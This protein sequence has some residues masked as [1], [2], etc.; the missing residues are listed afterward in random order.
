MDSPPVRFSLAF[1]KKV[2]AEFERG[3]LNKDQLQEKYGIR[4]NSTVL[5]WCRKYG[6][7]HY[8]QKGELG[9]PMKDP[10]KQRIKDLEKQLADAKLQIEAYQKLIEISEAEEK[11]SILKKGRRQTISELAKT[12]PRKVSMFCA[13]FG[14]SKQAYYKKIKA[15]QKRVQIREEVKKSVLELRRQMPKLGTRKLHYLLK[16]KGISIGRDQLFCWLRS[17]GLLVYK[18]KRYT[19]TTNSKHW[20]RKYP[21]VIK[22]LTISRPDQVWVADITYLDTAQDGNAY[23]HLITDAYSKQIM[24]YELCNNMEAA[25]TL[26]ALEMAVKSRRYRG[27]PLIHHSDRGL[28]YCSKLYID[29]LIK[30]NITISMTENGS[31]YDNAVAERVNGIL[32][33]EFGLAEQLDNY[34]EASVQVKESIYAYNFLRPHLSCNMLTPD[35]MHQQET[36]KIKTY[37]KTQTSLVNV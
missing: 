22:G 25:S 28:Q 1:K 30:N 15:D 18:K 3:F 31:P 26:K 14:I 20:M 21:N 17:Q 11:I 8:A 4:G 37:K 12:Y 5:K 2:V 23:L 9:R 29:C 24:G 35:Q 10:Q 19:V 34:R 36:I 33:D 32:K 7:L 27:L 13:L 16:N 6:K